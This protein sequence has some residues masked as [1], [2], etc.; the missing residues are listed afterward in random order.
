MYEGVNAVFD[1]SLSSCETIVM[2]ETAK[3]Q[4]LSFK[5]ESIHHIQE[6]RG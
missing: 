5:L 6:M 4:E 1:C 3:F 2:A